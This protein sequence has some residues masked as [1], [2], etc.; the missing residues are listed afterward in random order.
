MQ[1]VSIEQDT[2]K[3]WGRYQW[4]M[5]ISEWMNKW[6]CEV[7]SMLFECLDVQVP[8]VFRQGELGGLGVWMDAWFS[9]SSANT[10]NSVASQ[11]S[12]LDLHGQT[13]LRTK[14]KGLGYGHKATYRP[15]IVSHVNSVMTSAMAIAKVTLATFLHSWFWFYFQGNIQEYH[16]PGYINMM[17]RHYHAWALP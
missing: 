11:L 15:G 16:Q 6:I 10:A 14:G 7:L 12:M 5:D 4:N 17:C 3:D 2:L 9:H 1:C 8:P 13:L